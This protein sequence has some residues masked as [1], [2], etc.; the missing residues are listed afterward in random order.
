M[1]KL[2]NKI[3]IQSVSKWKR[4]LF[5]RR[6]KSRL[7]FLLPKNRKLQIC[8]GRVSPSL[9]KICKWNSLHQWGT[10]LRFIGK[11]NICSER[12]SLVEAGN[13]NSFDVNVK[14]KIWVVGCSTWIDWASGP[15]RRGNITFWL[16]IQPWSYTTLAGISIF[17]EYGKRYVTV[18]SMPD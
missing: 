11:Q 18:E 5:G 10:H 8:I 15:P 16:N 4:T 17:L 1:L 14:R 7:K 3:S 12:S 6:I 2:G 13:R 9:G